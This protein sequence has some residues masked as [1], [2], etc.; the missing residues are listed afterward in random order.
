MNVKWVTLPLLSLLLTLTGT[1]EAKDVLLAEKGQARCIVV[2]PVGW[3]KDAELAEGLPG[4]AAR[5]VK[6]RRTVFQ[7]SVNDLAH[8][9]GKMSGTKVEIVEGLPAREKRLPI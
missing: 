4:K 2:V 7:E 3:T 1:A 9:L 5:V 6:Q 8:Y